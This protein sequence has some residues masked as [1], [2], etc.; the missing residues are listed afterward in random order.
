MKF[1]RFKT[2][3]YTFFLSFAVFFMVSLQAV[4]FA[5]EDP[6]V[7]KPFQP[8]RPYPGGSS[9]SRWSTEALDGGGRL[10]L[11]RRITDDRLVVMPYVPPR[12]SGRYV[13]V[14]WGGAVR[15][16]VST[17]Y[18]T[19]AAPEGSEDDNYDERHASSDD[20]AFVKL[21]VDR[22]GVE[23]LERV[24]HST[25]PNDFANNAN[26]EDL[27]LNFSN[28]SLSAQVRLFLLVNYFLSLKKYYT[29][30]K[31]SDA[32]MLGAAF[33][34][35]CVVLSNLLADGIQRANWPSADEVK[36]R[37]G[38]VVP[39]VLGVYVDDLLLACESDRCA[40][41]AL[42]N[43]WQ[44][45]TFLDDMKVEYLDAVL[46]VFVEEQFPG[47]MY[48]MA[49]YFLADKMTR[50]LERLRDRLD[51]KEQGLEEEEFPEEDIQPQEEVGIAALSLEKLDEYVAS[52]KRQR[53]NLLH[54]LAAEDIDD[55]KSAEILKFLGDIEKSLS[56]IETS[57]QEFSITGDVQISAILMVFSK[58]EE[59]LLRGG[60]S[61]LGASYKDRITTIIK[62]ILNM[63]ELVNRVVNA[64][65]GSSP[66]GAV[67]FATV[68]LLG[69]IDCLAVHEP[70]FAKMIHE[71]VKIFVGNVK[72]QYKPWNDVLLQK[73][74]IAQSFVY[75]K[76]V[77]PALNMFLK[78][79]SAY[80]SSTDFLISSF[81]FS[82]EGMGVDAPRYSGAPLVPGKG[83]RLYSDATKPEEERG[84][85]DPADFEKNPWRKA[86][87]VFDSTTFRNKNESKESSDS[88]DKKT[89]ESVQLAGIDE[90]TR[91]E[92]AENVRKSVENWSLNISFDDNPSW[93]TVQMLSIVTSWLKT[94]VILDDVQLLKSDITMQ[95]TINAYWGD[96]LLFL[97]KVFKES[98]SFSSEDFED[99]ENMSKI[100][101]EVCA[102]YVA[103]L[104]KLISSTKVFDVF[105]QVNKDR[106]FALFKQA[107]TRAKTDPG[108]ISDIR[109]SDLSGLIGRI[110]LAFNNDNP[111]PGIAM[112]DALFS[113]EKAILADDL[114]DEGLS[115]KKVLLIDVICALGMEKRILQ[116]FEKLSSLNF[117]KQYIQVLRA[118]DVL[119]DSFF[120]RDS[121]FFYKKIESNTMMWQFGLKDLRG[122]Q[123]K[124]KAAIS[125]ESEPFKFDKISITIRSVNELRMKPAFVSEIFA[126]LFRD[127]GLKQ[128]VV[129]ME[130]RLRGL[131]DNPFAFMYN[132]LF[133]KSDEKSKKLFAKDDVA[134]D[135]VFGEYVGT[136]KKKKAAQKKDRSLEPLIMLRGL[137]Y[138]LQ[139]DAFN[140][141]KLGY[142]VAEH[143][144]AVVNYIA[145]KYSVRL[146]DSNDFLGKMFY[147]V[148]HNLK[149][150]YLLDPSS[151]AG[152]VLLRHTITAFNVCQA[153]AK[154]IDPKA[155]VPDLS[156]VAKE[157]DSKYNDILPVL[158]GTK[159]IVVPVDS[160]IPMRPVTVVMSRPSVQI[161]QG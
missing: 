48:S 52:F 51:R 14:G 141:G 114:L 64:M 71:D 153:Q 59:L 98:R 32:W 105:N 24:L 113:P 33:N 128:S 155:M 17:T 89:V 150:M 146:A 73:P 139:T 123:Q 5:D 87:T 37:D 154:A 115:G 157:F 151:Y 132:A 19:P 77:T 50:D 30:V 80:S 13:S 42:F 152:S 131:C 83:L 22:N 148:V 121:S 144:L 147:S 60:A 10:G 38:S 67:F 111:I 4:T 108:F 117:N 100:A 149:T 76:R 86:F 109:R 57:L 103:Q 15:D 129:D 29:E 7:F 75:T 53:N 23:W 104:L 69:F 91:S 84:V 65:D 70:D 156:R 79:P 133:L 45:Y 16:G 130:S 88:G 159:K 135:Y 81:P 96:Q 127:K 63:G 102:Q 66:L 18:K 62:R 68:D 160:S 56:L 27:L 93:L 28:L 112:L 110:E 20:D 6:M 78:G 136:S 26:L 40:V 137:I 82:F 134:R 122:Y 47:K 34:K 125:G 107:S 124:I 145:A 95:K 39:T 118:W 140:R 119:L 101:S 8:K 1:Y 55:L 72:K 46:K 43:V 21:Q 11:G 99:V 161:L 2:L 116:L 25:P 92:F 9:S 41:N 74:Q 35:R 54:V 36:K 31:K 44:A 49:G 143:L 90:K 142:A 106:A 94:L 58:L 126:A 158:D 138:L 97:E 85:I 3:F 12:D 120:K 61:L